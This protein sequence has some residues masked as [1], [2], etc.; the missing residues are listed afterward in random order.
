VATVGQERRGRSAVTS[1]QQRQ[2]RHADSA[3]DRFGECLPN[4][5]LLPLSSLLH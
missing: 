5:E 2:Q 4:A 1:V 3:R